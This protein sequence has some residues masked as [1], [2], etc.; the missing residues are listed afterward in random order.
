MR[1][2]HHNLTNIQDKL[3]KADNAANKVYS[4]LKEF[5][6]DPVYEIE[7]L[8]KNIARRYL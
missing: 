3:V 1:E 5:A 7:M 4:N 2:I 8:K 6:D